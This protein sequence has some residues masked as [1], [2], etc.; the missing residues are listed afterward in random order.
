MPFALNE[1]TRFISP[2]ETPE[3]LAA[4]LAVVSTPITDVVRHY[5][6]VEAV[7]IADGAKAFVSE[8]ERALTLQARRGSWLDEIG[9]LL[10][11]TAPGTGCRASCATRWRTARARPNRCGC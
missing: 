11:G 10:P 9:A 5:G 7:R 3:Y 4:G 6:E 8:C 1:S 2:T